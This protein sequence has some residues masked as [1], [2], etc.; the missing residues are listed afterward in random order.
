M[1]S[2]TLHRVRLQRRLEKAGVASSLRI[3]V[4]EKRVVTLAKNPNASRSKEGADENIFYSKNK[5]IL[6]WLVIIP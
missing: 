1:T 6:G 3:G 2:E 5:Y 4:R